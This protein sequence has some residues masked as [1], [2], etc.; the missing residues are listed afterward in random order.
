MTDDA[1]DIID[2]TRSDTST[3]SPDRSTSSSWLRSTVLALHAPRAICGND[4][5]TS[6]TNGSAGHNANL[7][8]DGNTDSGADA[9]ADADGD[10][11]GD[12]DAEC[13]TERSWLRSTSQIVYNDARTDGDGDIS[14]GT[15]TVRW[16]LNTVPME[17]QIVSLQLMVCAG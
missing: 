14:N 15:A 13:D 12:A 9:D 7:V 11:D 8:A 4:H 5:T 10:G 2:G 6:E 16:Q 1:T 3:E 17:T